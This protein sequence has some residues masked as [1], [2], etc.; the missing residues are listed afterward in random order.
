M[1]K[2]TRMA[3]GLGELQELL[4]YRF[5]D[6][7]LLE[8]AMTHASIRSEERPANERLEFLGDAVVGLIVSL[9]LFETWPDLTEGEMTI[10]KSSVVSRATMAR[11][12]RAMGLPR[13]LRVDEGLQQRERYPGS[14]VANVYEA[15][16]GAIFLDG[17]LG[18][19]RRFVLRTL[20]PEVARARSRPEPST[21]KSIL[22]ERVQA[23]GG[24]VPRYEVVHRAGPD[25]AREYEAVVEVD[26]KRQ[27][28][29]RGSTKKAAEQE[30]AREALDRL[31]PGWRE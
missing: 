1:Q 22:Q 10:I 14:M 8:R 6:V 7:K 23:H 12:G 21:W 27:G 3:E 5:E 31:F 30:A 24:P 2:G 9:H 19:A 4:D 11:V 26:G 25:H 17:G 28:A 15:A 29:G 16:V 20:G 13:F 18:A